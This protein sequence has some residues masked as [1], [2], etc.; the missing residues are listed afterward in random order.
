ML[1]ISKVSKFMVASGLDA[2]EDASQAAITILLQ[3]VDHKVSEF[4]DVLSGLQ[5]DSEPSKSA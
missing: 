3:D 4:C 1:M 2:N 5:Q